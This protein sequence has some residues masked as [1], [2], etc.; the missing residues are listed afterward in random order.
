M[1][2]LLRY[3]DWVS[4]GLALLVLLLSLLLLEV[5]RMNSSRSC[6]PPGPTPLPFVGNAIQTTRDPMTCFRSLNQ[7][8][9]MS[10]VYL[11]RKPIIVL[12]SMELMKEAYIHKGSVF[13][14]RP[15]MPL[16]DW[17]THGYG[18]LM[19]TYCNA[20][21]EQ[22]RFVLHTLRNFGLGKKSVEERVNEE[23]QYLV[24]ELQQHEGNPFYPIHPIM[25]AVSNII[26]S[27]VFGDRFDYNNKRF[28][29]LLELLNENIRL[30]GTAA[31]QIFNFFPFIKH[32]PGPH[33]K[34]HSNASALTGFIRKSVVE[35]RNTLDP[36]N[37]RDFIDAYLVEM[38]K[39]KSE[40]NSTFHEENLVMTTLDLFFA[41]TDTTATTLRW[42][43]IF[44]MDNPNVQE[45]CH[46]EIVRVLGY[47]RAP[48]MDDRSRLPYTYATVHEIQ[49]LGNIVPLGGVHETTQPTQLRGYNIAKGTMI[50]TN[51]TAVFTDKEYWKHPETFNPENFL[52]EEGQFCKQEHFIPFSL[53]PRVC[54]GESLARTEL[55][56]FFTSLIQH[57]QFSWPP[58]VPRPNMDGNMGMIRTP[59]P[60]NTCC[61]S[62]EPTH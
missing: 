53:G 30:T 3:V 29:K 56:L 23:A 42:G 17:I 15:F 48:S 27:I 18:I 28:A 2:S 24:R 5:F 60:F 26:C 1:Q 7:Y 52:D 9:D 36:E 4:A 31:A 57:L 12:N 54:L 49:R 62:R 55:F 44:M 45:R 16:M 43:L 25:N 58:G 13:S 61:R 37:L 47:D 22:R 46:E 32:I 19:V 14:G 33:Q 21:K 35:H 41:G 59:Y 20:W 50:M 6:T 34:I 11:G 38:S 8:G 40:D 10:T 39:H 51:L